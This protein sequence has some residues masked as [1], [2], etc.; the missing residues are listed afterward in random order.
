MFR[1]RVYI[2]SAKCKKTLGEQLLNYFYLYGVKM[3]D[4]L[5]PPNPNEFDNATLTFNLSLFGPTSTLVSW[6][7]KLNRVRK[8]REK[9]YSKYVSQS[10][11]WWMRRNKREREEATY[12]SFIRVFQVDIWM[13]PTSSYC[14]QLTRHYHVDVQVP[15][16]GK[17]MGERR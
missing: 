11:N 1:K 14:L 2:P 12:H 15:E 17:K 10:K 5:C 9:T 7:A 4:E 3:I 13:N 6:K 16:K 8:P